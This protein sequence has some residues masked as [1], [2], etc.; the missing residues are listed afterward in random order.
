VC[1]CCASQLLLV[2]QTTLDLRT[3]AKNVDFTQAATTK[4]NKSGTALPATCGVGETFFLTTAAAGQNLYGCTTVNTWSP[5]GANTLP[6]NSQPGQVL[7]WNGTSWQPKSGLDVNIALAFASIADGTCAEQS[8]SLSFPWPAGSPVTLAMPT[9]Y[10][11][12]TNGTCYAPAGLLPSVRIT[13]TGVA[14][15]RM[16]NFSGA[17]Q[18]LPMA[19][20]G[21]AQYGT[22][23][24]TATL[25]FPAIND[26]GCATLSVTVPG[27]TAASAIALGLPPALEQGLIVA[28]TPAGPNSVAITACNWSGAALTPAPASYQVS[29]I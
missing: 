17:A 26:G 15:L 27:A 7:E 21:V 18:A 12:A 5:I 11:N 6:A 8:A 22:N 4:P 9:Q 25:T 10:C 28:G 29:V 23:P 19:S 3:Q 2:G 16:C 20:Y 24:T 14:T 1:A 13:N